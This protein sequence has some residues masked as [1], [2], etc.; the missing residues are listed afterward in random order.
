MD[1]T[2]FPERF[3][4]KW[5]FLEQLK[6]KQTACVLIRREFFL[7]AESGLEYLLFITANSFFQLFINGSL[8]GAGPRLHQEQETSYIDAYDVT[9]D[10]QP[11]KNVIAVHLF[12]NSPPDQ[13][14]LSLCPG[15]WCQLQSGSKTLLASDDSWQLLA[16]ETAASLPGSSYNVC[17]LRQIPEN[18]NIPEYQCD[19]HWKKADLYTLPGTAGALMELHPLIPGEINPETVEFQKLCTGSVEKLPVFSNFIFPGSFQGRDGA[20]VSYIFSDTSLKIPV[21]LYADIPVKFYCG[22]TL[23]WDGNKAAGSEVELC[24][25]KGWTRLLIFSPSIK[26]DTGIMLAAKEWPEELI[27]LNDMLDSAQPGW[28]TVPLNKI[29]FPECTSA[30]RAENIPG[31]TATESDIANVSS[32]RELLKHSNFTISQDKE[33]EWLTSNDFILWELPEVHYGF[34]TVEFFAREGDIV[35]MIS[36]IKGSDDALLPECFFGES[37]TGVSCICREGKNEFSWPIPI[38]CS[39]I[40]FWVRRAQGS[41]LLRQISFEELRC[42]FERENEFRC[43]EKIF[44]DFWKTGVAAL[45]RSSALLCPTDGTVK[46]DSFLLDSFL[47]SVNIASVYGDSAYITSNLR[48]FA[49]TQ[50]ENGALTTLSAGKDHISSLFHMFFFPGWIIFNYR[51]TSNMVELRNLI[52]RLD[53]VKHY[54]VSLLDEKKGLLDT[55][56]IPPCAPTEDDPVACCRLPVVMNALFCRFMMTA[57]EIYDLVERTSEARLCR[58]LLRQVSAALIENFYD[59]ETGMF[60]DFPI[61]PDGHEDFS[62][63]GNFFPLLAGMKTQEC[64]EKFVKTFFDF[65][66]AEPLTA[67]ADSPYFHWLFGEML[68]ALGQKEWGTRYLRAY[69]QKRVDLPRGVW[70]E[71]FCRGIGATCF[72]GG[73]TLV[74]NAFLIREILGVRLAEPAHSVIYFDP[75]LLIVDSAEGAI[76]TA[77]GR[78]RIKWEK[79]SDGGLEVDIFSTHPI[80]VLPELSEELLKKST[81]RL[82][83]NVILVRSAAR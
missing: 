82:G 19:S 43:S 20:A 11:G 31:L 47:E 30:V 68:F 32:I 22:R 37:C 27:P 70:K 3:S 67:E 24:L 39:R 5:I 77:Q 60:A 13:A 57:S 55:S 34:V 38:D 46:K 40:L 74:P 18:W 15:M 56:L 48:Q 35:D 16:P 8:V 78:I 76:S 29:R 45:C 65:D 33:K 21:K 9:L 64:F 51:F 28:C 10:L 83:E 66:K 72:T 61:T 69:W 6:N 36:G 17:D 52:H 4:G 73:R 25:A 79:Q 14:D 54:L 53:G 12:W 71:P 2:Q 7:Q 59:Q 44:N 50:L 42:N 63:L 23:L 81:F 75:G 62:L 1:I 26:C 80:K 49:G 58:R 41:L